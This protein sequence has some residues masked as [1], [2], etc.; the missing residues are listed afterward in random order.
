MSTDKIY[1]DATR[2]ATLR[3]AE[4]SVHCFTLR[5]A[6]LAWNR[7]PPGQRRTATIKV[8]DGTLYQESEIRRLR[9]GREAG[10]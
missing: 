4:R 10:Q 5:E 8:V 6:K 7:L 3:Y 9:R 2:P 1:M